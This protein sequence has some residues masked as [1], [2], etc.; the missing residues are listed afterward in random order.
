MAVNLNTATYEELMTIPG[1]GEKRAMGILALREK[2]VHANY[3]RE[4]WTGEIWW[5]R[6]KL[7]LGISSPT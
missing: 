1:V 3:W 2:G 4:I 5:P 6:P 7:L